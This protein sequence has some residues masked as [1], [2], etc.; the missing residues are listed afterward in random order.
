MKAIKVLLISMAMT[1]V[2]ICVPMMRV[3]EN[4][5]LTGGVTDTSGAVIPLIRSAKGPKTQKEWF[6]AAAFA[7]PTAPWNGGPNQGFG[8]AGKDA[9]VGS[10]IFKW[11]LALFK[12]ISLSSQEGTRLEI[13]FESFNTFNHT[14]L[15]DL[16]KDIR[17]TQ[18]GQTA[19]ADDPRVL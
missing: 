3:Q 13:R 6:N 4:V 18:F 2:M 19:S 14:E 11:N 8:S 12:S 9:V 17:D 7:A 10:G 16:G 5:E 1:G 15:K